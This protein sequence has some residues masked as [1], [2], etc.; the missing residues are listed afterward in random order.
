MKRLFGLPIM[1]TAIGQLSSFYSSTKERNQLLKLTLE[2]AESGVGV[3]VS[4]TVPMVSRFDKE[5][6]ALNDIACAQLDI[7]EC[8]CPIITKPTDEVVKETKELCY[9]AVQPVVNRVNS[10]KNYGYDK[11]SGIR[12]YTGEKINGVKTYGMNTVAAAAKVGS[13][14][15]TRVL[16]IPVCRGVVNKFDGALDVADRYVDDYLPSEHGVEANAE[17]TPSDVILLSKAYQLGSKVQR[18]V[19]ARAMKRLRGVQLRARETIGQLNYTVDLIEYARS[20]FS[21]A[22]DK[23]HY[24][25]QEINKME[26]QVAEDASNEQIG[27]Y[28]SN[29]ERKAIATAR[30]LTTRLKNTLSWVNASS[31]GSIPEAVRGKLG[32]LQDMVHSLSE[33]FSK[34]MVKV[35]GLPNSALDNARNTMVQLYDSLSDL[36]DWTLKNSSSSSLVSSMLGY[37]LFNG[38]ARHNE[39]DAENTPS[40]SE[41]QRQE[42]RETKTDHEPS[43]D[44]DQW[45]EK[46]GK[47]QQD[48]EEEED[49]EEME[50]GDENPMKRC[51]A[52]CD[53]AEPQHDVDERSNNP[54]ND[55]VREDKNTEGMEKQQDEQTGMDEEKGKDPDGCDVW[56]KEDS[57]TQKINEEDID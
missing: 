12:T 35:K 45:N 20:N 51:A 22:Q 29:F 30:H 11:V 5:I 25:W 1:A 15:V 16:S 41:N 13:D 32:R 19:Y 48:A 57:E 50:N 49:E 54:Q 47:R 27:Y 10:V 38:G 9:V 4:T 6:V 17:K 28:D 26:D 24:Y 14:Q 44:D 2:T 36:V 8:R 33:V 3:I 52:D 53:P 56:E 21:G 40:D 31:V 37:N 55:E 42:E 39:N 23:L 43:V 18:R 34:E 46:T 7:L